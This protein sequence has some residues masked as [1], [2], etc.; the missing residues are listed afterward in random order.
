MKGRSGNEVESGMKGRSGNEVES[1]M[2]S[3]NL[4]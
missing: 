3:T 2:N 1:G 4:S